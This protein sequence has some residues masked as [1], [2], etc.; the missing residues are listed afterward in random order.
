MFHFN[1]SFLKKKVEKFLFL[2]AVNYIKLTN[3]FLENFI[4][5]C[6][7]V[8]FACIITPRDLLDIKNLLLHDLKFYLYYACFFFFFRFIAFLIIESKK[9]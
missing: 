1:S 7:I 5:I 8:V 3:I 2:L 6:I 4:L 9:L